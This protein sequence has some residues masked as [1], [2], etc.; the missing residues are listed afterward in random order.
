MAVF[1]CSVGG[2]ERLKREARSGDGFVVD[3]NREL[4]RNANGLVS[5]KPSE[6]PC[7]STATLK[8]G[9]VR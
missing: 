6:E 2:P 8:C 9:R 3:L 4:R 5:T 7:V 1:F